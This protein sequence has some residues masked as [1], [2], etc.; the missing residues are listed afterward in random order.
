MVMLGWEASSLK[1]PCLCQVLLPLSTQAPLILKFTRYCFI[2]LF[3]S[4]KW[5]HTFFKY[6]D[7]FVTSTFQPKI[8]WLPTWYFYLFACLEFTVWTIKICKFWK[9]FNA[10]Y[11]PLNIIQNILLCWKEQ[12][13]CFNYLFCL[14]LNQTLGSHWSNISIDYHFLECHYSM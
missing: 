13:L 6:L 10:L 12:K 4:L 7:Y 3:P 5:F 14:T 9:M 1:I 11:L 2:W 8:L